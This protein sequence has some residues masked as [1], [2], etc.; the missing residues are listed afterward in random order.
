M[1]LL[2]KSLLDRSLLDGSL[3]SES[4]LDGSFLDGSHFDGSLLDG[5]GR[6]RIEWQTE[7]ELNISLKAWNYRVPRN[8]KEEE[9]KIFK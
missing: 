8:I 1:S 5:S 4:L 2:D 9:E 6:A 3:L 7:K